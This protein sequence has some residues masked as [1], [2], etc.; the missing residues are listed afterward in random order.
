MSLRERI[1]KKI[2]K[3]YDGHPDADTIRNE[4]DASGD[5][6]NLRGLTNRERQKLL[7]RRARR[8][9]EFDDPKEHTTER[10]YGRAA[11]NAMLAAEAGDASV[12]RT[13]EAPHLGEITIR[14]VESEEQ[15]PVHVDHQEHPP[16]A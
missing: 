10:R 16:V 9:R 14:K 8:G 11:T 2:D 1:A 13:P 7:E 12:T 4:L 5:E 3:A 15:I 6:P